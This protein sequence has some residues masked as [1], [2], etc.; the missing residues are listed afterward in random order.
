MSP[1]E[2]ARRARFSAFMSSYYAARAADVAAL[3]AATAMYATEVAEY[4]ATVGAPMHFK[5]WLIQS[6]GIPR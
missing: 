6:A 2:R 5:K 3:E 4:I 1:R